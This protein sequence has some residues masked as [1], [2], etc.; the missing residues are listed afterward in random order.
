[1]LTFQRALNAQQEDQR[2][3]VEGF[4]DGQRHKL[5]V[6]RLHGGQGTGQQAFHVPTTVWQLTL[7]G[8]P[9]A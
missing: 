6:V 5:A 4:L 3:K 1:V 2:G 8:L 9:A 7:A